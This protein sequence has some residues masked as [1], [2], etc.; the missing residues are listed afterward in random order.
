MYIM[1]PEVLLKAVRLI[2]ALRFIQA[3]L[4][5]EQLLLEAP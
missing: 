1:G 4:Y 2:H 3:L 5:K